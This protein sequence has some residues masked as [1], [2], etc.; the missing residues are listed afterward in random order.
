MPRLIRYLWM[1]PAVFFLGCRPNDKELPPVDVERLSELVADL[2]L[3]E[4][5]SVEIP[6]TLRDSM[7]AIYTERVLADHDFTAAEFD[8][9]MWI[10]RSEPIWMESFFEAVSDRLAVL[11][12][13][14]SRVPP[15]VDNN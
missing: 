12:A 10:V 15:G 3:M 5:M 9:L 11:E 8:S 4:G 1:L 13:K 14:Q 6:I 7:K 2:H